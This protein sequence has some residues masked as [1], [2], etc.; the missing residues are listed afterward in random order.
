M[1]IINSKTCVQGDFPFNLVKGDTE[2]VAKGDKDLVV[3]VL[4]H[5]GGAIE[6]ILSLEQRG[7][8]VRG[9]SHP[10]FT[11][12][13]AGSA[14]FER[15]VVVSAANA[16]VKHNINVLIVTNIIRITRESDIQIVA[17]IHEEPG[18]FN[19]I[20]TICRNHAHMAYIRVLPFIRIRVP[21]YALSA[22]RR[23]Y[24]RKTAVDYRRVGCIITIKLQQ[25]SRALL[26]MAKNRE[27]GKHCEKKQIARIFFHGALLFV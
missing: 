10:E 24:V 9:A 11:V 25:I 20:Q 2:I 18:C 19:G 17:V 21:V 12:I 27:C 5:P 7:S 22:F 6:G 16:L 14:A 15:I 8:L 1:V 3:V 23:G 13:N 26:N 4:L